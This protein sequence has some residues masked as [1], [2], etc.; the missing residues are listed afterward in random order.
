[1]RWS[2]ALLFV[3]GLAIG[4]ASVSGCATRCGASDSRL[5]ALQRGMSYEETSRIMRC[6]GMPVTQ[7]GPLAAG[8]AIVEWDGPGSSFLSRTRIE[9]LEGKLLSYSTEYRGGL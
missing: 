4:L 1:M 3:P 9:F 2:V 7:Q 5:A 6:P 8:F